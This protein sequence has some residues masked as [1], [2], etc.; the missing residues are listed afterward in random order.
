MINKIK[1]V[2]LSVFLFS[3]LAVLILAGFVQAQTIMP[4]VT[5]GMSFEY[6]L[7]CSWKSSDSSYN[8]AIP[9]NFRLINQT[10]CVEVRVSAVN[11]THVTVATPWYFKDGTST[12]ER[13]AIN[14]HT[15]D[16][17]GFVGIIAANLNVGDKIHPS[18][19]DGLR[20]LDTTKKNYGG[21]SRATNHIQIVSEDTAGGYK[22]T[23]DLYFDKETGI[24]VEQIDRT[25][26]TTAPFITS[27]ATWKIS[28]VYGVDDWVITNSFPL[29]PVVIVIVIVAV[30]VVAILFYKKK[31]STNCHNK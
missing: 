25:E 10:T 22:G 4:G 2:T 15:G 21:G 11:N 5:Q 16:G 9:Q 30:I 24:L 29:I 14:L 17:Y 27:Q 18:G 1:L 19:D 6:N 20:V 31:V 13:G 28:A 23:R 7:S 3:T 26:T 12:L 8:A